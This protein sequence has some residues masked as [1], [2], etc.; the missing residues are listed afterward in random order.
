[1]NKSKKIAI[2]VITIL[3]AVGLSGFAS[4][5]SA[6]DGGQN[7]ERHRMDP[8]TRQAWKQ[9]L[10]NNDYEAWLAIAGDKPITEKINEENFSQFVEAFNLKEAGDFEGAKAIFDELG[11]EKKPHRKHGPKM[12]PEKRDAIKAALE[13]GDYEAWLAAVGDGPVTE[14]INADNFDQLVEAHRLMQEGDKE[15][16]KAIFKELGL[17]RPGAHRGPHRR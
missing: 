12:D 13:A 14:K 7:Q 11:L 6:D 1:M 3:S 2:A 9:A 16:A 17:K 5:A 10:E 4:V 15:G 8:E